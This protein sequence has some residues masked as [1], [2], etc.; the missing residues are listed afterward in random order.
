[1][2]H[3]EYFRALIL[4]D[5]VLFPPRVIALWK[6]IKA[7]GLGYRWHPLISGA[8]KRRRNFDSLENLFKSYRR[9]EVF[10][11]FSDTALWAYVNGITKPSDSGGFELI[12]SPEWEARIYYTG[13]W[14]DME[15]WRRLPTLKVPTLII[16]GAETD[17]FMLSAAQRVKHLR[18]ETNLVTI[19]KSTHLVPLERPQETYQTIQDFLKEII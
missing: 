14:Q 2:K 10:R 7:L 5:P 3:P 13:I 1:L 19:E 8:L 9:K 12:Y 17:T 6:V 18:P 16:R 15:L 4:I 11:Y